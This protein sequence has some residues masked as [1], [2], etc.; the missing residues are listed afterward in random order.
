MEAFPDY[1]F[2]RSQPQLYAFAERD[3]PELFDAIRRRIVKGRW[4]PMGGMWVEADCIS[5]ADPGAGAAGPALFSG[6]V[7]RRRGAGPVAARH[8]RLHLVAAT[9]GPGG[10]LKWFVTNK[11]SWNQYTAMPA[12]LFRWQGIDGT[13]VLAHFLT[14]PRDIQYLPSTTYKCDLGAEEF[15]YLAQL[16]PEEPLANSCGIRLWRRRRRPAAT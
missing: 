6:A 12:Q 2:S 9:D 10:G 13:Q 1:R 7:R 11:L 15:R 14:T 8:V 4:E 3:Q 5:G 16:H